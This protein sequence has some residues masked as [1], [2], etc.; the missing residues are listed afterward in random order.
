MIW[1]KNRARKRLALLTVAG[2]ALCCARW[3]GFTLPVW[4]F[5]M[6]SGLV[7]SH[8]STDKPV[9]ALSFDDGPDPTY[10]PRVL[11]ILKR[12]GA[13]ATFFEEGRMIRLHPDLVR[14]V[15]AE[16]H[17]LGNHTD[18]HPYI[19]RLSRDQVSSQIG[20]CDDALASVV[21]VRTHLF[22]PPR[23]AWNPTVFHEAINHGDHIVLWSVAL[24]HQ[25]TPLPMQMAARVLGIV[26]PGAIILMHD[27][28]NISR[29]S[30]IQALPLLLDGLRA[31][32]Y[33]F[34]TIP[35]LL[36]IPGCVP[37]TVFR[38][39]LESVAGTTG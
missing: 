33:R 16:G 37:I 20:A 25:A 18:T 14:R 31:K 12:Y 23:G 7:V 35:D 4:L 27:G 13:K 5:E 2:A 30:T 28:A 19:E 36:K 15:I 3:N 24:E 1:L 22:R 38:N 29:E 21:G 6:H 32:G 9:V 11:D 8:A 39:H 26:R 17:V 34:V 10:T